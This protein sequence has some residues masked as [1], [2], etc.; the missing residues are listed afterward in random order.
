MKRLSIVILAIVVLLLGAYLG[1]GAFVYNTISVVQASCGS[2]Y[3]NANRGNTPQ[4]FERMTAES[5]EPADPAEPV[6]YQTDMSDFQMTESDYETVS[7]PAR[8]DA[9]VT[10]SGWFV[11]GESESDSRPVVI[12]VHG[13]NGCKQD[14]TVLL[15]AG[16]LV[17]DGFD[18]LL[19]DLRN[20]GASTVIDGRFAAGVLEYRDVLGAWDYLRERGYAAES[21]GLVGHSLGAATVLVA[22]G[23]EPGIQATW[24]DSSFSNLYTTIV[25]ELDRF[26]FPDFFAN[27]AI[28]MGRVIGGVDISARSPLQ[29]VEKIGD[30]A[31]YL[32]HGTADERLSVVYSEELDAEFEAQGGDSELWIVPDMAHVEAI[33]GFRDEYRERM[34]SFFRENL[35]VS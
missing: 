26:G 2:P 5:A 18:V 13:L 4:N 12:V 22:A 10:I 7:F 32:T 16:M 27:S 17:K 30:R 1:L 19:M 33:Y 14:P 8:E 20:H 9:E 35:S 28:L 21:I 23:E 24:A 6:R 15:T 34:I 29:A 25:A 3:S 11:P 31:V